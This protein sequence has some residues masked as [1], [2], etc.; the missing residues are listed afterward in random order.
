M[1]IRDDMCILTKM[2]TFA[3]FIANRSG[4]ELGLKSPSKHFASKK[5]THD[6]IRSY[7]F[8]LACILDYYTNM[9]FDEAVSEWNRS[10]QNTN[11]TRWSSSKWKEMIEFYID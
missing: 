2:H 7:G 11:R 3:E 1:S 4:D 5:V 9:D 10:P 8:T 6:R